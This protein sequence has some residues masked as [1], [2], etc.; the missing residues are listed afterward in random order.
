MQ[1]LNTST[2][3]I[4]SMSKS[5]KSVKDRAIISTITIRKLLPSLPMRLR[6]S[7]VVVTRDVDSKEYGFMDITERLVQT[8]FLGCSLC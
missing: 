2:L 1:S 4:I 7:L 8:Y 3:P 5:F 6:S